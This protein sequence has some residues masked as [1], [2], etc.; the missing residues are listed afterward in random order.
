MRDY[1]DQVA[2]GGEGAGGV[3]NPKGLLP[4][5]ERVPK[6]FGKVE[7]EWRTWEEDAL[8]LIHI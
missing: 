6:T 3:K 4:A 2:A 7:A 1:K 8:S 5:K